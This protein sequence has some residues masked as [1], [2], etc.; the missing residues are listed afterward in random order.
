MRAPFAIACSTSTGVPILRPDAEA[1]DALEAVANSPV[2]R[3]LV[4]DGDRLVGLLSIT[5]LA[6][7]LEAAPRRAPASSD[8]APR[9]AS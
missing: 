5:D 8:A 4:L 9:A 7:A 1:I 3:G 6:R 2:N